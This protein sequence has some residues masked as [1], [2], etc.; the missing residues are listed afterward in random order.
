M[1]CGGTGIA[2]FIAFCQEKEKLMETAIDK[3]PGE[4]TLYFGCRHQ[5]GD[6]IFKDQI[7]GYV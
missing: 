4:Y 3:C 6:F 2:P 5:E 1:V 7:K